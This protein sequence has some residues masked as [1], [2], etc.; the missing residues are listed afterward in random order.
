MN[1]LYILAI[2]VAVTTFS[3]KKSDGDPAPTSQ[4]VL[5][6]ENYSKVVYATYDD[7]WIAAKNLRAAAADFIADPSQAG[8]EDVRAAYLASRTPYIQSE[9]FRFATGPIDEEVDGVTLEGMLNSWPLDESYIDYV[10]GN[11]DAGII[12]DLVKFPTI[13]KEIIAAKNQTAGEESV[14]CGYHAVEFLLWGQD[15]SENGPGNRPY[16]DYVTGTK[17]TN[18][19]QTRRGQYLL[20]CIDLLIDNLNT[21]R[22]DWA[23][24]AANYRAKLLV[25]PSASIANMLTG[26]FKYADGELSVERMGAALESDDPNDD[27]DRQELEQSC[28]SDQT[29][30][31]IILGQKGIKNVYLGEYVRITGDIVSGTSLSDMIKAIDVK[32]D[33]TVRAKIYNA[34]IKI[35]AIHAP[36]DNE[37]VTTNPAGRIRVLNAI[38]ALHEEAAQYQAAGAKLNMIIH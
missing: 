15:F 13:N 18:S 33:S 30:N 7:S 21:L 17:G 4:Q 26:A 28:F 14:S 25:N 29:N 5:V 19:N 27:D 31:D 24:G 1:K 37:I 36:F 22:Q 20:A 38:N 3:C 8:L 23:P 34:D 12:N 35:A 10:D 16:T 6:V 11:D 32:T 2:A 9:A